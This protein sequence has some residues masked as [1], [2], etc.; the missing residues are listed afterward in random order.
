MIREYCLTLQQSA[1]RAEHARVYRLEGLV[2]DGVLEDN[3]VE[4]VARLIMMQLARAESFTYGR[5]TSNIWALA[6]VYERSALT[7]HHLLMIPELT[8][9]PP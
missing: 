5:Q 3:R 1:A 9:R 8:L 7:L 2:V 4:V 6:A